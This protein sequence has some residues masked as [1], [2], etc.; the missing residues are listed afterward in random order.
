MHETRQHERLAN[1]GLAREREELKANSFLGES[2]LKEWF[3]TGKRKQPSEEGIVRVAKIYIYILYSSL[4]PSLKLREIQ[5][6]IITQHN[7]AMGNCT[8]RREEGVAREIEAE[9]E[10]RRISPR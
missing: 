1:V 9:Q 8:L 5:G 3:T 4:N 6:T 10:S 2:K 7:Y